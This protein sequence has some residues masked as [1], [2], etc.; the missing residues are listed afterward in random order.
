MPAFHEIGEPH[1]SKRIPGS[2]Q[3]GPWELICGRPCHYLSSCW[4]LMLSH[5]INFLWPACVA[6][7]TSLQFLLPSPESPSHHIIWWAPGESVPSHLVVCS[8]FS[9]GPAWVW[10]LFELNEYLQAL[11]GPGCCCLPCSGSWW[12]HLLA[13]QWKYCILA[14]MLQ[15]SFSPLD[16]SLL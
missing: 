4:I 5:L 9:W 11:L 2:A 15:S 13:S 16:Q 12:D 7:P 10:K 6:T 3:Q 14:R 8:S 1:S